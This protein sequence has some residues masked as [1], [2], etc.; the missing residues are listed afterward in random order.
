MGDV[1]APHVIEELETEAEIAVAAAIVH[2]VQPKC[3]KRSWFDLVISSDGKHSCVIRQKT[4]TIR[5]SYTRGDV[6][7]KIWPA[8]QFCHVLM[9]Q[10]G[11]FMYVFL[12]Y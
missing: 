12:F 3:R 11:S 7:E 2:Q 6:E 1:S 5:V 4:K 8:E 10:G 9:L